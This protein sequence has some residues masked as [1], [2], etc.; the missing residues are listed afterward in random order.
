MFRANRQLNI[1]ANLENLASQE[2]AFGLS[3][4]VL[5]GKALLL[6]CEFGT[7]AGES[8]ICFE[9][10]VF[11]DWKLFLWDCG[12]N[13]ARSLGCTSTKSLVV[14]AGLSGQDQLWEW[15]GQCVVSQ[16]EV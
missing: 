16:N 2:N 3:K 5:V 9:Q 13:A 8:P 1:F 12:F 6:I 4:A 11:V 10:D 15:Q 14:A 7:A